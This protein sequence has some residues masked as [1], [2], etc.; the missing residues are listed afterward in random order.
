MKKVIAY[1]R[2]STET[3]DPKRQLELI[4]AY[5]DKNN[6]EIVK[7]I[8]EKISGAKSDRQGRAELLT[9]SGEDGD[10]VIISETSRLS[11]EEDILK[12]LNNVNDLLEAGLDVLFLDGEKSFKSGAVLTLFQIMQLAFEAQANSDER[13]KIAERTLSGRKSKFKQGCF[14]GHKVAYGYKCIFQS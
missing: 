6:F 4:K 14:V 13:K 5:C 7:T 1:L 3:Q 2:V 11:R 9:L 12:L 10:I 8:S